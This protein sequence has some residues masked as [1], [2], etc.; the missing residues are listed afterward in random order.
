MHELSKSIPR[1]LHDSNYITRYF[2]GAGIDIGAGP[3]PLT[4][5]IELF[6]LITT[7]RAWDK[8]DGDAE[9]MMSCA[10]NQYDFV[11]SSHCLEHM[12]NPDVA[13]KNWFRILK[14][15]G[16]LVVTVP[17]E[18][19]YEQGVF[20][21]TFNPDHKWT[22]TIFK[23]SSWSNRS[24]NVIEMIMT[25]GE[26]ADPI[27]VEQ[28][29]NT[30]R[31]KL[32]RRDQTQ[33]PIGES[34]IEFVVRKRFK[35]E[36][37][38]GGCLAQARDARASR[39]KLNRQ[40]IF[41][42]LRFLRDARIDE[43]AEL[44]QS[45]IIPYATYSPWND[46]PAFLSAYQA[47]KTHTL[48]DLYRCYDLWR[49]IREVSTL[50][51]DVLEVGVWRGGTGCLLGLAMKDARI[52]GK[53]YLADSFKG[54]VKASEADS[55]Y[56]GGEHADTTLETVKALLAANHV[57]NCAILVGVFPEET[58]K[59]IDREQIRF[60]HIDV[61]VYES[62]KDVFEWVWPRI[63]LGGIV[64]FDDYGFAT[65]SGVTK[66]VNMQSGRG[67]VVLMHNLNGHAVL[68]KTRQ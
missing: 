55:T 30:Y 51:G 63:P 8:K 65:C 42:N 25:L 61:D 28:L 6:P 60:C 58:A 27:K 47:I 32:P 43:S 18:D 21:S 53:L 4:R 46:S 34:A 49:L 20:P 45:V 48:V 24:R 41:N 9:L 22:F 44:P 14:P 54:V 17:D 11:H 59:Q 35:D 38:A 50:Q 39:L 36:V 7:I 26:S 19:M 10:D 37:E 52:D 2:T 5:Y 16:H 56:K 3:D 31:F 62:A 1:R 66:F 29:I 23:T 15:G 64:V 68:V 33:T 13:L 67:D 40:M 12:Q 57:E